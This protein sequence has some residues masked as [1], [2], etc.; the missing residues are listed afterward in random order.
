MEKTLK[1]KLKLL[2][3]KIFRSKI[4]KNF[5]SYKNFYFYIGV[6]LLAKIGFYSFFFNES[7]V[8]Y[9]NKIS[10]IAVS[11]GDTESYLNPV[12]NYLLTGE[13]NTY[14]MPGYGMVYFIFRAFFSDALA[15]SLIIFLQ[16]VLS[17]V[18]VYVLGLISN[19]LIKNSFFVSYF[20]Y[21]ISTYVSIYDQYLLTESLTTSVLILCVFILLYSNRS[22]FNLLLSGIMAT[23]LFFLKPVMGVFVIIS[24][25]YLFTRKVKHALIFILPFIISES[26]WIIRNYSKHNEIM[27]FTVM[28]IKDFNDVIYY[29]GQKNSYVSCLD[30]FLKSFGGSSSGYLR[31]AEINFFR[32]LPR[33]L[34]EK[35]LIKIKY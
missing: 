30:K 26:G 9:F 1:N 28:K 2:L 4:R 20:L 19:R 10:G 11:W 32:E 7:K 21:L 15:K 34:K 33:Y 12:D 6:A 17:S 31:D 22:I 13:F 8:F 29:E 27:P 16:I 3:L 18:S 5:F 14:R 23:W 35:K 24:F 25:F